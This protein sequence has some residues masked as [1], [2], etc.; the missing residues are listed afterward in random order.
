MLF[1]SPK[2]FD[3]LAAIGHGIAGSPT[4]V[5]N[6]L[7]ELT[8][9]TGVNYMACHMVFGNMRFE[10]AAT[11]VRLLAREVIPTLQGRH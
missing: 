4:T 11:S 6:F 7:E 8:R 3:E 9:D 10:A 1:R 2:S 5:L